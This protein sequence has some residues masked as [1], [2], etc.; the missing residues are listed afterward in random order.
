MPSDRS[1]PPDP[2]QDGYTGVVFQQG[3]VTLDRDFNTLREIIDRRAGLIAR[4]VVGPFGTP[5]KN[6]FAVSFP[7]SALPA[8]SGLRLIA[9]PVEVRET[10][11]PGAI[12]RPTPGA[13]KRPYDLDISP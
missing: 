7:S 1:R 13:L 8:V 6:G 12:A 3:R 11:I 5:D 10:R 2:A 4:D 9:T